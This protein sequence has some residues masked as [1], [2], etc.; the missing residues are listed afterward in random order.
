MRANK[1]VMLTEEAH[2][3]LKVYAAKNKIPTL[4]KAVQRLLSAVK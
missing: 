2:T 1:P 4:N 3:N